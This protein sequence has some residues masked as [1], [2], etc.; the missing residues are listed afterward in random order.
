MAEVDIEIRR[1]TRAE[2]ITFDTGRQE[3]LWSWLEAAMQAS[4]AG[5]GVTARAA[6]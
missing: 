2:A 1:E 6:E 5:M 3:R 4:T